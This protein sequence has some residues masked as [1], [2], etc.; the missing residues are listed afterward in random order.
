MGEQVQ[1]AGMGDALGAISQDPRLGAS[2]EKAA[3]EMQKL[4][5]MTVRSTMHLILAPE[6]QALDVEAALRPPTGD[7]PDRAAAMAQM[8][9][10]ME[11]GG[12]DAG[13][14]TQQMTLLRVTTQVSDLQIDPIPAEFFD[15]PDGYSEVEMF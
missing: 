12:S 1:E 14:V 13:A 11:A 6:G 10:N 8:A 2:M 3:E 7:D 15:I 5:G 4:E 9:E